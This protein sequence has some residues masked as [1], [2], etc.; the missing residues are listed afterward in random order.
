MSK[1]E[2]YEA[3]LRCVERYGF[4]M[5]MLVVVLYFLRVD[6]VIPIVEAHGQFLK[7]MTVTQREISQAVQEQTRLLYA[8]DPELR[9]FQVGDTSIPESGKN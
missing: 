6:V 4:P 3:V 7:E 9:Y 5:V 1:T 2:V 8:L